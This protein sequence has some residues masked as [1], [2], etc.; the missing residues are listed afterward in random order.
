MITNEKAIFVNPLAILE[1]IKQSDEY[2]ERS[3]LYRRTVFTPQDW[4]QFRSSE[5]HGKNL[6]KKLGSIN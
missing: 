1:S 4:I 6:G 3:R 2:K 5:R